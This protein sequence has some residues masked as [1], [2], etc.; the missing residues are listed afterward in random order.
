MATLNGMSMKQFLKQHG[1]HFFERGLFAPEGNDGEGRI[2][3]LEDT[4][5]E[6][7]MLNSEMQLA[8]GIAPGT[9]ANFTDEMLD[10][11]SIARVGPIRLMQA[12]EKK[13]RMF[14]DSRHVDLYLGADDAYA[15]IAREFKG[16]SQDEIR[17][18]VKDKV[19]HAV[20]AHEL[21]HSFNLHHNF[22][23][24][25]D[26]VNYADGYWELRKA[27]GTVGPR[28]DDPIT[29]AELDGN[30]Y[31]YSYSSIMDYSRLTLDFG[32]GKYDRAAILL[33]YADKVEMFKNL[34]G[35]DPSILNDW[36]SNDGQIIQFFID[37]PRAFHYTEWYRLMGDDVYKAEN[38]VLVDAANVNWDAGISP[39]DGLY[40][41]P[42]VFCSP[43]Q[44]DI[45]NNCY[46]RDYGA[47]E[48]ERI[49][50][51][52]QS[53][54]TWYI[55]R[56]FPRFQVGA[57]VSSYI[58]RTYD[59]VYGRMKNYNDLYTLYTGLFAQI[60][61]PQQIETFLTDSRTGWGSYTRAQGEALNFLF[62]TIAMPDVT[63]FERTKDAA[64]R[65]VLAKSLF[66]GAPVETDVAN[67]R[68]FTTS[69]SDS[70]FGDDCGM[71]FYECLN[72]YG[73]YMDKVMAMYALSDAQTN[74]V[75]RDTA[76]D[77]REFRISFYDSYPLVI[78]E[79]FGALMS[80]DWAQFAPRWTGS[81]IALPNWMTGEKPAGEV[82]D[83]STGF[84]VQLYAAVLGMARF[85]NNFDKGFLL[86]TRTWVEGSSFGVNGP[87]GICEYTDPSGTTY[88][89]I[90]F[91]EDK[92]GG[93]IAKRMITYA[94]KV[95][96]R[97][98]SCGDG[99]GVCAP[100]VT[101][102]EKTKADLELV[103]YSQ[104][105]DIMV[106]L[107]GYYETYTQQFGPAYDPGQL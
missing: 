84:T 35:M 29:Q 49:T 101:A 69:W 21:G 17:A 103:R 86:S 93:G 82:I 28:F 45:G 61:T 1:S 37:A 87:Y 51:H 27:D 54:R 30:I 38:R 34:G 36:S 25:E 75:A 66:S 89:A 74:F 60:Y 105:L 40:R 9:Q 44:S 104:L 42:Y 3:A 57:D 98:S 10:S 46:T 95:K 65:D 90:D 55:T 15:G 107:T 24:T 67:A 97:S 22:G 92:H 106:D 70:N 100:G 88:Q 78:D 47:D 91:P 50:H 19:F 83:P 32:P 71:Y 99:G 43:F 13:K 81:D 56:A 85:Q 33:G 12:I 5:L 31:R 68:F 59:R 7:L 18:A 94:N 26:V 11:A 80:Q 23:G 4:Y 20:L 48:Y 73:F 16:K 14:A 41:V 53:A 2:S 76:E 96:E 58:G 62:E 39:S 79:F 6:N 77:I 102:A 64:G 52:V 8:A 63:G 72:H